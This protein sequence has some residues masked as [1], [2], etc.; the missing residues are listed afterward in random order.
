MCGVVGYIGNRQALPLIMNGLKRLEYRGYDSAGVAVHDSGEVQI[1]KESG[2]LSE[3]E[4][5]LNKF[6]IH[7]SMGIGHTRWATH[8]EPNRTNA[9]PHNGLNGE[10]SIIVNGIVENYSE[11]KQFLSRKGH[12]FKSETDT[13]V[14]AHFIEY[15]Y[16]MNDDLDQAVRDALSQ[17][18]GA[19]GLVAISRKD[20][21]K[22]VAARKGSPLIVGI[23]KDE[24]FVA[25]DVAAIVD[26]TRN[27]IYLNDGEMVILTRTNYEIKTIDNKSL[28]HVV[29]EV[30][31]NIEAIE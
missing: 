19:Y 1:V 8:G 21:D 7:G 11:L 26:S 10:I 22:I 30:T 12:T 9:H 16:E 24:Y 5:L 20:P 17:V 28:T 31:Y 3:L 4:K 18:V 23:G 29:Q 27:V 14:L 15:F 2:K 25:S 6:E 13:E